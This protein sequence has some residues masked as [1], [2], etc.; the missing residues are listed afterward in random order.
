M[1]YC[2]DTNVFFSP[3]NQ[4]YPMSYC[5]AY[6]ELLDNHFESGNMFIID[7]VYDELTVG[8][9]DVTEWVKEKNNTDAVKS[10]YDEAVQETYRRIVTYVNDNYDR[11]E[12]INK[13]LDVADPWLIAV[14][15]THGHTLVTKETWVPNN[16]TKVKIPNVCKALGFEDYIDEFEMIERLQEEFTLGQ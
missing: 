16:S 8:E 7:R 3:A 14:C 6:W 4:Y 5:T 15:M 1:A 9:S 13:F 11:E 2:L 10:I 12:E